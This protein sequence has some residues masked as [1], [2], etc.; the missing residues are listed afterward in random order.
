MYKQHLRAAQSSL[1]LVPASSISNFRRDATRA[2]TKLKAIWTS[3]EREGHEP[4]SNNPFLLSLFKLCSCESYELCVWTHWERERE[5]EPKCQSTAGQ[6]SVL[7]TAAD[8]SAHILCW[9][10]RTVSRVFC[11]EILW[12]VKPPHEVFIYLML[13]F[14]Y[15]G[16]FCLG[17]ISN[18]Q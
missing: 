7:C 14:S 16:I 11:H 2:N 18:S 13:F 17:L 6:T 15:L 12:C 5:R 10:S 1:A 4:H 8:V 3:R 9:F